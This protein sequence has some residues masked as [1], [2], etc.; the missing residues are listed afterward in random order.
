MLAASLSTTRRSAA[1]AG[2]TDGSAGGTGGADV[3]DGLADHRAHRRLIEGLEAAVGERGESPGD[4]LCD[5]LRAAGDGD[6]GA[7]GQ[8]VV[9]RGRGGRVGVSRARRLGAGGDGTEDRG[10]GAGDVQEPVRLR[11]GD[12]ELR[13]AVRL[14]ARVGEG[15]PDAGGVRVPDPGGE[16]RHGA[17]DVVHRLAQPGRHLPGLR[18]AQ[19]RPRGFGDV[20]LA[21]V[22]LAHVSIVLRGGGPGQ[23]VPGC[24]TQS[25]T[26]SQ[27]TPSTWGNG[28]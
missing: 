23:G 26:A 3:T 15:C 24:V 9:E 21:V 4:Q 2:S 7:L 12:A 8:A 28:L 25:L 17:P 19:G 1:S 22:V 11:A 20:V 18:R 5:V 13:V 14:P 16:H 27:L 6:Q 10:E